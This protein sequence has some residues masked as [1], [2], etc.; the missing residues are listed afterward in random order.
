[1]SIGDNWVTIENRPIVTLN[2]LMYRLLYV[3]DNCGNSKYKTPGRSYRH[4]SEKKRYISKKIRRFFLEIY[5]K[6]RK[7]YRIFFG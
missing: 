4:I 1:M 3:G 2:I 5:R 7:I 6:F